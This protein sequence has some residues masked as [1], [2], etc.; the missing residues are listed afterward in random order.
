MLIIITWLP[1]SGLRLRLLL[2]NLFLEDLEHLF[3]LLLFL[4]LLH[5]CLRTRFFTLLALIDFLKSLL[6]VQLLHLFFEHLF[7]LLELLLY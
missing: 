5:H 7:V 6:Q 2:N 3:L 4:P 1:L